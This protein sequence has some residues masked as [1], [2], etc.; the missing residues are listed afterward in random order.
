MRTAGRRLAGGGSS[1]LAGASPETSEERAGWGGALFE[2]PQTTGGQGHGGGARHADLVL[3]SVRRTPGLT[4]GEL[5]G[6]TELGHIEA[7]RR[8]S[9]LKNA[10]LVR[11]GE[12]RR[13]GVKGS[14]MVTWFATE[15]PS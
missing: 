10:H 8:L 5:G 6:L 11:A 1:G 15:V 3:A 4:A 14:R 12:P 13:C 9:D 7:Q 2:P